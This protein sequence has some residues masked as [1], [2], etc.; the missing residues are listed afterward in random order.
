MASL[1]VAALYGDAQL[2]KALLDHNHNPNVSDKELRSPLYHAAFHG[3]RSVAEALISSGAD[4]NYVA[5]DGT[6]ALHASLNLSLRNRESHQNL[7]GFPREE[8]G[9]STMSKLLLEHGAHPGIRA[10]PGF[11]PLHLAAQGGESEI[12]GILVEKGAEVGVKSPGGFTPLHS[13]ARGAG[14]RTVV[15]VL[16]DNGADAN[17]RT[18]EGGTT[19]LHVA[20]EHG[21]LAVTEALLEMGADANVRISQGGATP[22]HLAAKYGRVAAAE[23]LLKNGAE[24]D[25][26][27]DTYM[28]PLVQAMADNQIEMFEFLVAR[29]ADT[30]IAREFQILHKHGVG[31]EPCRKVLVRLTTDVPADIPVT[32]R[33]VE[34][35]EEWEVWTDADGLNLADSLLKRLNLG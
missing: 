17:V 34:S 33:E 2:T 11:T 31:E 16:L 32:L 21:N 23:V 24:I 29:G 27:D 5:E 25:T 1:N 26:R 18:S 13:A 12:V 4:V 9:A 35:N 28:T 8:V 3:Y 15:K 6:T 22:L 7:P 10:G 14:D 30:T 20:A 19:P